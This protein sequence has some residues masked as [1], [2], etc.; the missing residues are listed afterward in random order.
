MKSIRNTAKCNSPKL[1]SFLHS[2]RFDHLWCGM[3]WT[4]IR[5]DT[6]RWD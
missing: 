5:A 3:F 4:Q 1:H 2:S 6:D